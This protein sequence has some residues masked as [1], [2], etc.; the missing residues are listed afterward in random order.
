M[1]HSSSST[2]TRKAFIASAILLIGLALIVAGI[3]ISISVG[4]A[5]IPLNTVIDSFLRYN[6]SDIQHQIILQLRTPRAVAGALVGAAFACSGAIMQGVTQN[7]LADSGLLGIN[8]G[9]SF[10][11]VLV[12]AFYPNLSFEHMIYFSFAGAG[13]GI[14]LIY[15]IAYFAKGKLTPL[16][17]TLAGVVIG[18][19][20]KS[21]SQA[22]ALLS[23]AS[24]DLAFWSAGGISSVE[25][26]QIRI[27]APWIL[28]GL[29]LAFIASTK[30][31]LLSLGDEVAIGL[32]AKT[33]HIRILASL[34]VL[35]MVGSSVATVGGIGFVGLVIPH[36]VRA[37]VGVNYKIIIPYSAV[38]GAVLVVFADIAAKLTALPYEVP[39]SS[40]MAIIGVPF[41]L[42]LSRKE[43]R[44]F[45]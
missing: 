42:Y 24:Y 40:V 32:G 5:G 22:I 17:L 28:A 44:Y 35:I 2:F 18:S 39:L 11:I 9:T 37:L 16:R 19:L 1:K 31:T 10:V 33:N 14:L 3:I 45:K 27:M 4:A 15:G 20:L 36:I 13:L 7:P 6:S 38:L 25:W 26:F 34:S 41:F 21:A 43:K 12:F 30:L 23:G 29:V 8:A